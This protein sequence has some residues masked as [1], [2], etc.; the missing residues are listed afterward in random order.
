MIWR[1]GEGEEKGDC[2]NGLAC[3]DVVE[4]YTY[5]PELAERIVDDMQSI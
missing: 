2:R 3:L 1:V 4:W 5:T